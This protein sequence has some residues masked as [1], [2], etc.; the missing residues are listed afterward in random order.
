MIWGCT[1]IFPAMARE[2]RG[3]KARPPPRVILAYAGAKS[4]H[5]RRH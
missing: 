5:G 4:H 1:A 2:A 3:G